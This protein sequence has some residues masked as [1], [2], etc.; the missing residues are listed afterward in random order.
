MAAS[1]PSRYRRRYSLG[2]DD[3]DDDIKQKKPTT[4]NNND[5]P[6][7]HGFSLSLVARFVARANHA[8][9]ELAVKKLAKSTA[10]AEAGV[11]S[12]SIRVEGDIEAHYSDE[13]G[14]RRR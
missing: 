8:K 12:H 11:L 5:E 14:A 13:V 9:R 4:P 7:H 3:D 2:W 10:L 6:S 1:S